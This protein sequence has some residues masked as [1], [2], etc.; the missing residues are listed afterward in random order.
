MTDLQP[1]AKWLCVW[2]RYQ[3]LFRKPVIMTVS[4]CGF[5]QYLWAI[6]GILYHMRPKSL[7]FTFL[8]KRFHYSTLQN[9]KNLKF[10]QINRQKTGIVR[11]MQ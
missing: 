3:I 4:D 2:S 5:S 7:V 11:I 10:I 6:A 8:P 9:M 1:S